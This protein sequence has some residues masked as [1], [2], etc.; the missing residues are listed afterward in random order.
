MLPENP[1]ARICL[2]LG[3]KLPPN[4]GCGHVEPMV[5]R[6]L[7][8]TGLM[9][10]AWVPLSRKLAFTW[11]AGSA[12][13]AACGKPACMPLMR[14]ARLAVPDS[15]ATGRPSTLKSGEPTTPRTSARPITSVGSP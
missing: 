4:S 1:S 7:S 8:A 5:I 14:P 6:L 2:R 3:R 13:P 9:P 11:L 10:S 15:I 12:I